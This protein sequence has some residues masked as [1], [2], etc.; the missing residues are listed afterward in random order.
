MGQWLCGFGSLCGYVAMGEWLC[1]F[2]SLC[3]LLDYGTMAMADYGKMI[4]IV[5]SFPQVG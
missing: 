2:G 4:L 3:G 1:G 5:G